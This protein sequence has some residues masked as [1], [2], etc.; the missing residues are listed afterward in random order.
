MSDQ[1]IELRVVVKPNAKR[2]RLLAVKYGILHI[3][4]HAKPQEGEANRELIE[5]LAKLF[6]LPKSRIILRRGEKS[7]CKTILVPKHEGVKK[8]LLN[9]SGFMD[10]KI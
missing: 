7:K 4:L 10:L 3:A 1:Q 9:P 8:F 5:Y 2:S 6:R